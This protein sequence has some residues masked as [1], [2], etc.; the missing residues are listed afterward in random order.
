MLVHTRVHA[1][2]LNQFEVYFSIVFTPDEQALLHAV[3]DP[4][5]NKDLRRKGSDGRFGS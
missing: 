2:W 3:Q 1:C 5:G 4:K